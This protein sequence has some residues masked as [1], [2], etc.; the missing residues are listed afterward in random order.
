MIHQNIEFHNVAE[1][2]EVAGKSGLRLQRVP[3]EVRVSLNE[4]A[5]MRMLQP[6]TAEIRFLSDGPCRITVSSEGQTKV[7]VFNG[8]FDSMQRFII[9]TEPQVINIEVPE[10]LSQLDEKY[11]RDMSFSP[12]TYRLILGGTQRD[13]IFFHGI[14][15]SNV[16]PPEA[17]DLPESRY[18]AYGTSITHGW[19][20]EGPHLI[21]VSQTARHLGADLI[22]LGVGG[23]AFCEPELADY[24]GTRDDWDIATLAL[25]V[26]MQEFSLE[27]FSERVTYMV[28]AVSGSNP[29]RLVACITL[30]P[31][32]RDF[33]IEPTD[34]TFG[35]RPEQYRQAL[36]D[37]VSACPHPNAHL[38][39]GPEILTNISG[40][41]AD[42]IHPGDN[43][44]IEMGR[45]LGEKLKSLLQQSK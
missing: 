10:Y 8:L 39:E 44:M 7:T 5:Q 3:E 17:S 37:A 13:P 9:S 30:Y 4:D 41:T 21:Y 31:F 27:E 20:A 19:V 22:N 28:N 35:G 6:D 36:R 33:G 25:S 14:E 29:D 23:A 42:L 45:N 12:H 34:R 1:L 43:G 2:R 16:R 32:F 11:W 40:L 24:I 26:N 38:I 18:L 15:G